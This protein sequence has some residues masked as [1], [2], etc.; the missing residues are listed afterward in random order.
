MFCDTKTAVKVVLIAFG[1]IALLWVVTNPEI[2]SEA[3]IE[4][5]LLRHTP[6]VTSLEDVA[7]IIETKRWEVWNLDS[8][9]RW[10]PCFESGR[11][12][13]SR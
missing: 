10:K 9:G 3:H 8:D 12:R 7:K 11:E 5:D 2:R 4:R 1:A 13:M 6:I